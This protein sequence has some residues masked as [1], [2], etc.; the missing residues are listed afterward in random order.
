MVAQITFLREP[1]NHKKNVT[2][3]FLDPVMLADEKQKHGS[4]SLNFYLGFKQKETLS[5]DLLKC[6]LY[7]F[8]ACLST[9]TGGPSCTQVKAMLS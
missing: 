1:K 2:I 5:H 4:S 6:F 3:A 7:L 9:P 8:K